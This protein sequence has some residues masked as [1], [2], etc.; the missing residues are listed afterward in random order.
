LVSVSISKSSIASSL[1]GRQW[2]IGRRFAARG[3]AG[4]CGICFRIEASVLRTAQQKAMKIY[5]AA[6]ELAKDPEHRAPDPLRGTEARHLPPISERT[7]RR[8]P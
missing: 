3:A 1:A 4:R 2:R 7:F 5:Y 6:E 8:S